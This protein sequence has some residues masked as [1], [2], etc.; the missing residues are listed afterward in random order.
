MT[1]TQTLSR[2][3]TADIQNKKDALFLGFA[4]AVGISVMMNINAPLLAA[5]DL[6]LIPTEG[7]V[8]SNGTSIGKAFR[9][10]DF[11]FELILLYGI[12]LIQVG[13]VLAGVVYMIMNVY[14]GIMYIV[15][16][17]T[18]DKEAG[19]NALINAFLGFGLA[20]FS[21]IFVD[22]FITFFLQ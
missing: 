10:G 9:T 18:G 13:G 21:W 1:F 17:S 19:T 4:L 16:T 3:W 11:S 5:L 20:I 6:T 15:G 14:A 2:M 12:H 8:D 22:I 7:A